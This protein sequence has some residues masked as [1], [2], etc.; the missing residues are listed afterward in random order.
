MSTFSIDINKRT[1][2]ISTISIKNK[3]R[4]KEIRPDIND[5]N[6]TKTANITKIYE[7]RT[8]DNSL[9]PFNNN[10]RNVRFALDTT[11]IRQDE[12]NYYNWIYNPLFP[13][14]SNYLLCP[15]KISTIFQNGNYHWTHSTTNT[16]TGISSYPLK[17]QFVKVVDVLAASDR[18]CKYFDFSGDYVLDWSVEDGPKLLSSSNPGVSIGTFDFNVDGN[19]FNIFL[20]PNSDT[21]NTSYVHLAYRLPVRYRYA[22]EDW[23]FWESLIIDG[24]LSETE[25]VRVIDCCKN[26]EPELPTPTSTPTST[27]TPTPTPTEPPTPTPTSFLGANYAFTA[28]WNGSTNGNVT[29]VGSNGGSSFY[30]IYDQDGNVREIVDID[31]ISNPAMVTRGTA[32]NSIV[33]QNSYNSRSISDT[34]TE[35]NYVGLRIASF[36]NPLQL[37]NFR[38]VSDIGNSNNVDGY[39]G[40]N[41]SYKL[42][43][44]PVTNCE[45]VEFL[46]AKA[47]S[48]P[49]SLY[50]EASAFDIV[51]GIVRSGV[52]GSYTYAV[53]P[54]MENKPV[55]L[56]DWF[57]AARYCNWLHNSKGSGD[58]ESGAYTLSSFMIGNTINRNVGANYY[59]PTENEWYKAAYYKGGGTD[60]GYWTNS[61]QSNSEPVA[62]VPDMVGNGPQ[63][64]SYSC[65]E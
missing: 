41:Y 24:E 22:Y 45:Y 44:Y 62:I 33:T 10:R 17:S 53:K 4:N 32:W 6:N 54:N 34:A 38:D 7:K 20:Y 48:D 2:N 58:T 28:N 25:F 15:Q 57:N 30:G 46:N 9:I 39:G 1:N 56:I 36:S 16:N 19:R 59:I 14:P 21:Q 64:S 50:N 63:T 18:C 49:Y 31:G 12:F 52:D 55:V 23:A 60:A 51:S 65:P 27:P 61:L 42:C 13:R 40:V 3:I 35:Y 26:G 5:F 47:S 11:A 29:T 8:I 43:A 37:P